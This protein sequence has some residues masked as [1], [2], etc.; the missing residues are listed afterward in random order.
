MAL[1]GTMGNITNSLCNV[2]INLKR[3]VEVHDLFI[4]LLPTNLYK[5]LK[6][7]NSTANQPT[8]ISSITKAQRAVC[9]HQN[10]IA[11]NSQQLALRESLL[12]GGC[13][14]RSAQSLAALR[15]VIVEAF[16]RNGRQQQAQ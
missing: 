5:M 13:H 10:A 9:G 7:H 14:S 12:L 6:C 8:F 1:Y 2:W 3:N 15:H 11:W 4:K 16:S